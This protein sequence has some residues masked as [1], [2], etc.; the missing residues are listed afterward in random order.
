MPDDFQEIVD[1][2]IAT[3]EQARV[4][5]RLGLAI[6]AKLSADLLKKIEA[7]SR[8]DAATK[9]VLALRL[10][11]LIAK[12][13]NMTGLSAEWKDEVICALCFLR[14]W[15]KENA[16]DELLRTIIEQNK[17]ILENQKKAA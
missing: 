4:K 9:K 16:S 6:E 7:D 14:I 8:W 5:K 11:R 2:V 3:I 12:Y 15:N 13:A 17:Q 1:E 10:P